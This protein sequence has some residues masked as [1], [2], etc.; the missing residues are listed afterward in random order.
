MQV[1]NRIKLLRKGVAA[2]VAPKRPDRRKW[3]YIQ[4]EDG[5]IRLIKVDHATDADSYFAPED[6][7]DHTLTIHESLDALLEVQAQRGIDSGLFDGPCRMDCP[8]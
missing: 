1:R 3:M 7:L 4:P 8:L 2:E 6:I 5:S